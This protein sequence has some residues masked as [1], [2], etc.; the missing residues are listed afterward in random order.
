M[1]RGA[2]SSRAP[3]PF[4][5]VEAGPLA[6]GRRH[7]G[8]TFREMS[9]SHERGTWILHLE[10]KRLG[11]RRTYCHFPLRYISQGELSGPQRQL[12]ESGWLHPDSCYAPGCNSCDPS[13][14]IKHLSLLAYPGLEQLLAQLAASKSSFL[15][16]NS[17]NITC[18]P[19]DAA[20]D[21]VSI[22]RTCPV[23]EEL[24]LDR[25]D[26][27]RRGGQGAPPFKSTSRKAFT[28]SA[29]P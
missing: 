23:L 18:P 10:K 8:A 24:S 28:A 29:I 4:V 20:A 26:Y 16:L 19:A 12:H 13:G 2:H 17:L 25:L 6:P 9:E 1:S 21:I 15:Q 5:L 11:R 3:S 27:T 14:Q 7:F 22:L